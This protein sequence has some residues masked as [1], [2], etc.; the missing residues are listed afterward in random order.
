MDTTVASMDPSATVYATID[1]EVRRLMARSN[2]VD[3][4]FQRITDALPEIDK[5]H[6]CI[7]GSSLI[8]EKL[9]PMWARYQE[10][11]VRLCMLSS[12]L[13][14]RAQRN[15]HEFS[16]VILPCVLSETTSI[17]KKHEALTHFFQRMNPADRV[18]VEKASRDQE[19]ASFKE[20]V[21]MFLE[22][23]LKGV[24]YHH[25]DEDIK[26]LSTEIQAGVLEKIGGFSWIWELTLSDAALLRNSDLER[27][28]TDQSLKAR[29]ESMKTAYGILEC[30]LVEYARQIAQ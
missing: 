10:R 24:G 16:K 13:A 8:V 19:I 2:K 23:Y 27:I 3:D 6:L 7:D 28:R 21:Q 26:F 29:I 30:A 1:P 14:T 20:D 22:K 12:E 25:I 5:H 15:A 11:F 17:A 9:Q 4:T 18:D